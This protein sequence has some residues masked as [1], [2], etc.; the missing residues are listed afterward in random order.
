MSSGRSRIA[1]TVVNFSEG[2]VRCSPRRFHLRF[3]PFFGWEKDDRRRHGHHSYSFRS[4]PFARKPANLSRARLDQWLLAASA[5]SRAATLAHPD[6]FA[7]HRAH[8]H[9][10]PH[11]TL[12]RKSSRAP[13]A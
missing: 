11:L 7:R 13:R 4:R 2:T 5:G 12:V 3:L 1:A 9:L 6:R 10:F 8:A